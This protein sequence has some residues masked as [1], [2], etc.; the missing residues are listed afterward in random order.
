MPGLLSESIQIAK[1]ALGLLDEVPTPRGESPESFI[2]DYIAEREGLIKEAKVPTKGDVL[3]IGYGHTGDVK[4]GQT[5]TKEDAK[6]L[7]Q[8]DIQTR[9]SE[10]T[11]AIPMFG[12]LPVEIQAPLM[13][14]WFRGSLVQSRKTRKLLN[15][16]LYDQAARE[17]LNNQEYKNAV[18][19]GRRGIRKR[20]EETAQAI[21]NIGIM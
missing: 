1:A 13:S 19:R 5:I 4:R 16:G 8:K 3:T 2:A 15:E 21:R 9:T 20:M 14:E 11:R 18:K 12:N 7:L 17:F 10:I 6:K